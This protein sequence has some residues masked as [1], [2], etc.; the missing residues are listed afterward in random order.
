MDNLAQGATVTIEVQAVG[1]TATPCPA[2]IGTITCSNCQQPVVGSTITNAT[3]PGGANGRIAFT[4]DGLNPPYTFALTAQSNSTG[5]FN[6][7]SAG[8]YIA[9]V[10]DASGCQT[11]VAVTV[12]APAVLS[13]ALDPE[14]ITCFNGDDGAATALPTGGTSPYNFSWSDPAAQNTP[15]AVNLRTGAYTVTVTD[16]NGCTTTA[17]VTLAQPPDVLVFVT[18]TAAKCFGQATGLATVSASGGIGPYQ[19]AWSGGQTGPIATNLLAGS[20]LVT[21]TDAVGCAKTSFALIGQPTAITATS[22]ATDAT[23]ANLT[24]GSA[25][26]TA[27][28][29]T[30][31][32]TYL[33]ST[34]PAQTTAT[35]TNLAPGAYTVTISDQNNCTL[36]QTVTVQAPPAVSL[37][38]AGADVACHG[39]ATGTATGMAS[40]GSGTLVYQWSDPA[41]Q[42]SAAATNLVAGA[43]TVTVTDGNGCT[44]TA[45]VS[46]GQPQALALGLSA[47][48]VA[49]FG[50]N[51]GAVASSISGDSTPFG[52]LWSSGET[53]PDISQKPA[54]TYTVTV[55]DAVGCTTTA[56]ASISQPTALNVAATN[57]NIACFG[58]TDG[59]IQLTVDGGAMPYSVVWSGPNGFSGTGVAL[60]NLAAGS[61]TATVTDAAGCTRIQNSTLSQPAAALAISLPALGDTICFGA[62][63]GTATAGVTG[64]TAP[65]QYL[66][67]VANQTTAGIAGLSAGAYSVT[68]TDANACT[69][70]AS[71]FIPQQQLLTV[72][73]TGGSVDCSGSSNG[74]ATVTAVAY[75]TTP[76]GLSDFTYWWSTNPPQTGI[77]AT[78][79]QASQTYTVTATDARGCS[80]TQTAT[81][82]DVPSVEA[83]IIGTTNPSCFDGADGRIIAAGNG[84]VPPYTYN[85][86]AGVS[87]VDALA[88]NLR[89]GVYRV[90][91]VD[92]KGCTGVAVATLGQPTPLKIRFQPTAVL[93]FGENT[94]QA[95][96]L[97]EGGTPPYQFAW[98]TGTAGAEATGLAA[99]AYTVTLTD[100]NGC[101]HTDNV[102]IAQPNAPLG[103]AAAK[104]DVGCFGGYS[105]EIQIMGTGGTPP[106]RYALGAGNWNGSSK[107]IGLPAGIYIPRML[108]K[109]GCTAVLAP[110]EIEQR[111]KVELD[112]GPAITIRYGESIQLQAVATNA[113]DPVQYS[114]NPADS[115]WLSCLDCPDPFVDG[116]EY[117]HWFVL[118]IT[119]AF[120]CIAEARVLVEVEKL[121]RV[122][123]PTGFSPNGDGN[124]DLLLV[125]GQQGVRVVSFQVY[126]RWG[127]LVHEGR[128]FPINDP[129]VGW[130]GTFRGDALNPGVFVWV[131][132]VE[133]ADGVRE[134]YRG[135]TTLIR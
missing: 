18:P 45:S 55:T 35:A 89:A 3:C 61:Y 19:Y 103:G 52:Y 88:Q 124:N 66:W 86:D 21:V 82:G 92:S 131:M 25:T 9:T 101:T 38:V 37:S 54:G 83:I 10:T 30:G 121:R 133:F 134:V 65:Y 20:Y 108:D 93:C 111:P 53:T 6:N 132:E 24:N 94:G 17:S 120:G 77:A 119:D 27:Q 34:T 129:G 50:E 130:D 91:V 70:T 12:G 85:W 13:V 7:L 44:T 8:D 99:A 51:T 115:L 116:L 1:S 78:N 112:L 104:T 63:N 125:H 68:V 42:T 67:S 33:W 128:D 102:D 98:S 74:T 114:W 43:Y 95:R 76:A 127:E 106:Y 96:A 118:K 79:L 117:G 28:G 60:G 100:G 58:D 107:Q 90:T 80:A 59:S 5:I 29:G 64:G 15:K 46:I 87:A 47:V 36:T 73:A 39:A 32:K 126:D 71:I 81:I 31:A 135:N 69:A 2:L 105:G 123:V 75:G 110:V 56:S 22:T 41:A 26:T 48:A 84:G 4:T 109:N 40:G 16:L 11:Q 122:H 14:N 72:L 23:C 97:G 57:Q 49:C 62:A 113:A